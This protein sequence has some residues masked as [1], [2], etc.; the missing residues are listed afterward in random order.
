[1]RQGQTGLEASEDVTEKLGTL[2][3]EG[4]KPQGWALQ[5]VSNDSF[6]CYQDLS[7]YVGL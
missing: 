4:I 3:Q 7:E 2:S 5:D 6:V 1:M